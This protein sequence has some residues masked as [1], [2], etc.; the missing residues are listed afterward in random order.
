MKEN[1]D[2]RAEDDQERNEVVN[3]GR[4]QEILVTIKNFSSRRR[5]IATAGGM[6]AIQ[7]RVGSHDRPLTGWPTL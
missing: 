2:G 5:S 3:V 1:D 7:S 4:E 6:T